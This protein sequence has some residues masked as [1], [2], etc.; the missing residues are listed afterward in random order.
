MLHRKLEELQSIFKSREKWFEDQMKA[1]AFAQQKLEL[2]HME[3]K[4]LF[5]I[6]R[7]EWEQKVASLND[8]NQDLQTKYEALQ[9]SYSDSTSSILKQ[10]ETL[11]LLRKEN[12][13][14]KSRNEKLADNKQM[15]EEVEL[16]IKRKIDRLT[17]DLTKNIKMLKSEIHSK[18]DEREPSTSS[19]IKSDETSEL[20]GQF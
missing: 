6:N 20:R 10:N 2:A 19:S 8:L 9:K 12:L 5:D 11:I 7:M 1:A 3:E 17:D 4:K 16:G 14:L 18:K 15:A 13:H